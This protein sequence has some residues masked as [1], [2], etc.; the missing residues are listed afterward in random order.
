MSGD[1]QDL[2]VTKRAKAQKVKEAMRCKGRK[3]KLKRAVCDR[4]QMDHG[5]SLVFL[6]DGL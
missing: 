6:A 4:Q 2:M 5:A 1:L 3:K